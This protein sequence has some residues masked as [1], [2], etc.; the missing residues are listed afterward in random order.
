MVLHKF[1]LLIFNKIDTQ[2]SNQS[3]KLPALNLLLGYIN[4]QT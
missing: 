2:I 3:Y 1:A 4:I